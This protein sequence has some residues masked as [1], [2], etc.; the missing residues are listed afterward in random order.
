[1]VRCGWLAD[2][3]Q[4]LEVKLVGVA[5]AMNLGHDVLVIIVAQGPAQL[6]IVHV[7][8]ALALAPAPSHLIRIK[9][10]EFAVGALPGNAVE[11]GPVRKQLQEELP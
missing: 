11:V 3:G 10:F 6:V 4:A 8:F 9:Q 7:R 2:L 5:L 1:M